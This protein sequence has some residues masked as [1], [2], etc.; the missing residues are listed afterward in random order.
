M[1]ARHI[2]L[3][4][5]LAAAPVLAAGPAPEAPL[6]ASGTE[7]RDARGRPV[8]L[9]GVNLG[10]W[11]EWQ[12][13]MCPMDTS[14]TLRDANPGH[15]G[16]DFE[17]RRLL[18]SRFG[19]ATA[20]DLIRTYQDAWIGED[21]LDRIRALGFNVVRLT[22][23]HDT[24]IGADGR[25]RPDA[26]V[27][28]DW[29]VAR[30]WARG[31]HTIIDFH[32]FLPPAADQDGSAAGYW[33]SE[34]QKEETVRIWRGLATHY[35]GHP[36]VAMYDLLN[37]PNNSAPKG[38]PAPSAATVGELY[39]RL[40]RAIRAVDPDHAIAMEGVWDRSTLRDPRAAGYSNVVYSF[41]WYNWGGKTTEDRNRATDRNVESA[42]RMRDEWQVPAFIGEFNLFGD[43]DA[44]RH[45][46]DAYDRQRLSWTLWTWKNT[47]SGNNSWGVYTTVRGR[48]PPVPNLTADSAEKIRTAWAAWTTGGGGFALNP[49][50]EALLRAP[51]GI[52]KGRTP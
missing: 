46:L 1:N 4:L 38:R 44:W 23:G 2:A 7:L 27:R 37:E 13:W 31:I 26:F 35:R 22:L 30:A 20:A 49:M 28:A 43:R 51:D 9:R 8:Q 41:H 40:Y 32:A 14:K 24:L 25:G 50:F 21:D 10:G 29:L 3:L 18:E 48:V 36:G 6:K 11:L 16:Y 19:A 39:D 12:P 45:A 17:V 34:A 15:N 33:S 5:G 52:E 47:S 42:V